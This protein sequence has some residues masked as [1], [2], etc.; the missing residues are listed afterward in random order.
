[1]F[2]DAE[3]LSNLRYRSQKSNKNQSNSTEN[4]FVFSILLPPIHQNPTKPQKSTSNRF[5]RARL[6]RFPSPKTAVHDKKQLETAKGSRRIMKS[7]ENINLHQ[8]T[9]LIIQCFEE[10]VSK[11]AFI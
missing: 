10:V 4:Q 1:V 8:P 6:R 2:F 11:S 9:L 5:S 7:C 3:K